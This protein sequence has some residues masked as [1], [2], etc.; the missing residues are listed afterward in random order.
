[1]TKK[2]QTE[3]PPFL[4]KK[5]MENVLSEAGIPNPHTF[6]LAPYMNGDLDQDGTVYTCY[7]GKTELGNWKE[8]PFS[9]SFNGGP[10]KNVRQQLWDGEIIK[11]CESCQE[12][13]ANNSISPRINFFNRLYIPEPWEDTSTFYDILPD[14]LEQISEDPQ[15]GNISDIQR[16]EIRPSSL[17]NQRCMHCNPESSTKWIEALSKKENHDQVINQVEIHT[18][19]DH[20]RSVLGLMKGGGIVIPHDQLSKFYKGSLTSASK[21]EDEVVS[22]LNSSNE[23]AFTGGEPL[24][25]PEH[26]SQLDYIVNVS[27][28]AGTKTLSYNTNLNVKDISRYFKYWQKFQV[29]NLRISIDSDLAGYEYFRTYGN[30]EVLKE[31][32]K[33]VKE[34]QKIHPGHFILSGTVTFGMLS[35]LRW[36]QIIADWTEYGLEFHTSLILKHPISVKWLPK[37]LADKALEEMQWCL[38]NLDT[39]GDIS[40][41]QKKKIVHHTKDCMAYISGFNNQ[42][43]MMPPR[44]REYILFADRSSG[45]NY[46]DY[47]PELIP[48]ME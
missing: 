5:E 10:M 25:N 43:D 41:R 13:E 28:T 4:G 22:V 15:H 39:F 11:N 9:E 14:L 46:K 42:F 20:Q 19:E 30:M 23:I 8:D 35:A 38:D 36:K 1:M 29:M 45:N 40:K 7:R 12:A 27:K 17:C 48:F 3:K 34:Q 37:P 18:E 32:L 47:Y 16:T 33:L 21:Y 26:E 24:M 44:T 31:N 2:P 6:C